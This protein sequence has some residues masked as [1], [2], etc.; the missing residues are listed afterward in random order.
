MKF[1]RNAVI[2]IGAIAAFTLVVG[3]TAGAKALITGKDIKNGTI[4][5][6]DLKDDSVG[7]QKV[8]DG[9]LKIEDFN[10]TAQRKIVN[11]SPVSPPTSAPAPGGQ[12]GLANWGV[13]QMA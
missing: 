3:G 11:T 8:T 5:K 6:K 2:A 9:S 1:Q 13:I 7:T 12:T 10:S 4:A